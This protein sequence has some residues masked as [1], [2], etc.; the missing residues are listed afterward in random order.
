MSE[1]PKK[2][3]R[4]E[5]EPFIQAARQSGETAICATCGAFYSQAVEGVTVQELLTGK[6]A[7][8]VPLQCGVCGCEVFRCL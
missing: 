4:E 2:L 3:S 7:A 5:R 1:R 8:L 6:K